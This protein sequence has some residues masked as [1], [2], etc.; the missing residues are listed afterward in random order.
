M[1]SAHPSSKGSLHVL[2]ADFN[3]LSTIEAAANDILKTEQHLDVFFNNAGIMIPS[4]E[5]V[6]KQ[7]YEAQLGVIVL[8]PFLFTKLLGPV[9]GRGSRVVWVSRSAAR[10]FSPVGGVVMAKLGQKENWSQWQWYGI[11]K[12]AS[13]LLSA[14]MAQRMKS[15]GLTSVVGHPTN[16]KMLTVV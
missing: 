5:T 7:G 1:Q 14:E 2:E 8:A 16:V 12:A 10:S 13:I 4:V 6:T 11:S 15:E 3:D 9:L